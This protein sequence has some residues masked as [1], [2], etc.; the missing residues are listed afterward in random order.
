VADE[1]TQTP[2]PAPVPDSIP[3][4]LEPSAAPASIPIDLNPTYDPTQDKRAPFLKT[5]LNPTGPTIQEA[6]KPLTQ[7]VK[8]AV[9]ENIPEF[10]QRT[11]NDPKYG[12]KSFLP[13]SD[14]MTQQ[15]RK[16]L[17]VVAGAM[18]VASE[19]ASPGT[20]GTIAATAGLGEAPAI[21]SK[22]A[23][24]L[25]AGQIAKSVYDQYPALQAAVDKA[26]HA[27]S[28]QEHDDAFADAQKILTHMGVDTAFGLLA[29]KHG[30]EGAKDLLDATTGSGV[31]DEASTLK[32]KYQ[33]N[34]IAPR[35]PEPEEKPAAPEDVHPEMNRQT[36]KELQHLG[37]S[38][39]HIT[40]FNITEIRDILKNQ[41]PAS[42]YK[43]STTDRRW[44]P[45]LPNPAT[46]KPAPEPDKF[47]D[48]GG[49]LVGPQ[50]ETEAAA[51]K[52]SQTAENATE[53][54]DP[55]EDLIMSDKIQG[56][57][58]KGAT[59]KVEPT[60]LARSAGPTPSGLIERTT[61]DPKSDAAIKAGG[62]VPAGTMLGLVQ[63]HDPKTGSTLALKPEAV[64]P[65]AVQ[66]HLA[67]SRK[68]FGLTPE[69]DALAG[70]GGKFVGQQPAAA[71]A[72]YHPDLQK[73]IDDNGG[74]HSSAAKAVSPDEG[75]FITPDGKFV[76]V[77]GTHDIAIGRANPKDRPEGRI[78][79]RPSFLDDTGA[80][81]TRMRVTKAG[82]SL[83]VT[84]PKNGISP[85]QLDALR[86]SV[87][88]MGPY[89]N[90]VIERSDISR[91]NRDTAST[92]KEQVKPYQVE[93]ALR[94]IGAHPEQQD[95][96]S[97]ELHTPHKQ[98]YGMEVTDAEGKVQNVPIEAHSAKQA[99]NT[100]VKKFPD[101]HRWRL[102]T[103]PEEKAPSTDYSVPAGKIQKMKESAGRSEIHT[104]RHE[105]GHIFAGAAVGMKTN[106]MLS[107]SH[108]AMPSDARAAVAWSSDGLYEK[109]RIKPDKRLAVI[110]AS[111]GGIAA[112][113][114]FNDTPRSAN[115]NFDIRAGGDGTKA[116]ELLRDA[117]Y[118]HADAM[119]KMHEL[120]DTEVER[121][122][123]P[124]IMSV[125]HEN[126]GV[127]EPGL[128]RQYH[129]SPE[130]LNSIVAEANRRMTDEKYT[131]KRDNGAANGAVNQGR[132]GD[133]ARTESGVSPAVGSEP[134]KE[135]VIND[136]GAT[137]SGGSEISPADVANGK[138][139]SPQGTGE[140]VP[141]KEDLGLAKGEEDGIISEEK[142][143]KAKDSEEPPEIEPNKKLQASAQRYAK[144]QGM[145]PINHEPVEADPEH[146][147]EIAKIYEESKHEPNNPRV[148]AAYDALKAE[149]LAQFHHLRD[150]LGL[151]F[152]PQ[153]EDP[154]NSAEQMMDDIRKNNTLKVF[155]GSSTGEDH[156]LSAIA[157][158]TG[159]QSYNTVFRWVHDAMGHAAG[160]NDFSENGEKSATEAHAQMYSDTARPAMRNETEGQ[161]SWFFH[162]PEVESGAKQPGDFAEQKAA[163]IQDVSH[164]WHETIGKAAA[165]DEAGGINPRTGKSDT[166]GIGTEILP[167]FRQPL[168]HAPTPADFQKFYD[169][170][171]DLF[172]QHPELRVGFD[173]MS[174]VEGG[175][176]INIGAVGPNA[177]KVAAKLD[178]KSAFD[179]KKGEVIPTG[180]SGLKTDFKDYPLED[181]I[182]DLKSTPTRADKL[183]VRAQRTIAK[184]R[185]SAAFDP[186]DGG[187]PQ[188]PAA[189]PAPKGSENIPTVSTR[190]PSITANKQSIENHSDN[191]L[192]S[193]MQAAAA[194]P[195]FLKKLA[196]RVSDI[197]GFIDPGGD[198]HEARTNAYIRHV[199]DNT[200]F[201]QSKVTPEE[202]AT[203]S[204]WYP[205]GAHERGIDVAKKHGLDVHQAYAITAALSP[206]TDWDQNTA[207]AERAAEIWKNQQDT[208]FDTKMRKAADEILT[209]PE[210]EHFRKI[211]KSL[212]GKKLGELKTEGEQAW[213]LRLYEEGHYDRSFQTWNPDG[214]S[215]GLAMNSDGVTPKAMSWSFQSLIENAI[216]IMKDGSPENISKSL[217]EG[218]KVRNFYNNQLSPDDPRFLTVDTHQVNIG[219]LRPMS[220]SYPD[221]AD[222]F[223][224]PTNVPHGLSG[225]YVLHDAGTR[226]AAK[227][228]GID[229][230]SRLQSSGWV[231]I[232][233]VFP[234][235]FKTEENL[236]VIDAI[237]KEHTDGK[238][239]ADDAR[240]RIWDFAEG[241]NRDAARKVRNPSNSGELS[242]PGVRGEAS[243]AN[244]WGDRGD[245]AEEVS[246]PGVD[247]TSFDFG[248]NEKPVVAASRK[249]KGSEKSYAKK[250]A[251]VQ[252]LI[253]A[254]HDLKTPGKK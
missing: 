140:G 211:F 183:A 142:I 181:R 33:E 165:E 12:T 65:E 171:K 104:I 137:G 133:V 248:A 82:S 114:V 205:V 28:Q 42:E 1:T 213:W 250:A 168:G 35:A 192:T 102:A 131:E 7:R 157:P 177:A 116:Y 214:T 6:H 71:P 57:K 179:I 217:G 15:E 170:H 228:L 59:P 105:L 49:K 110:Q 197:P 119:E 219:Q 225:T 159:G 40:N 19:L 162:N 26:Q 178:Q 208:K 124:A 64:T 156:P 52:P 146:A 38:T 141:E 91:N 184:W 98:T 176:E 172:D 78:D 61:G 120:I 74:T 164:D 202:H 254:L 174:A 8:E 121:L 48:Q 86:R 161:T 191:S 186:S 241:W 44:N 242:E 200:K 87:Q 84:V 226:L 229:I 245:A 234:N 31:P 185:Q 53:T 169:R 37:Y 122:S 47:A 10:S 144:A 101:A 238:I 246:E 236:A 22:V 109:G 143:K 66:Q 56:K 182:K 210:M 149:T 223:G 154:Y 198:D 130:R 206:L 95:I 73:V 151:K 32:A 107:S 24:A 132:E 152:K 2:A 17:P 81:R 69:P 50:P 231:K 221:V 189:P 13:D 194:A 158:G 160:G 79:N 128:S 195:G 203:D 166:M 9:T 218:H 243:A 180:G 134:K 16:D 115:H 62:A 89:G 188:A 63:F 129:Y 204:Q 190:T 58:V 29:A 67:A 145:A 96:L 222:N 113:K 201:V 118:N 135:G 252:G 11:V 3:I 216:S 72:P 92:T 251:E 193:D 27:K 68:A 125:I 148:K 112:D 117:G 34:Q 207:Q 36:V 75:S 233:K 244:G 237:W 54:A 106:G 163:L 41:T 196:D 123:H 240:N 99:L 127:R 55:V 14:V 139:G 138:S 80:I 247:D 43:F 70:V 111:L 76:S 5:N 136:N 175:H 235:K 249:S 173:N 215:A 60:E 224:T 150:D 100:I 21:V 83:S 93:D 153:E 23:S 25:F 18:D 45:D 85:E 30:A 108:P 88:A 220:G 90:L 46:A 147:R 97:K 187:T 239:T 230:P 103:A 209:V 253:A 155:T 227:E 167:E 51:E 39:Q 199:A 212:E 4:D 94:E 20:I 77:K 232:R 126:A